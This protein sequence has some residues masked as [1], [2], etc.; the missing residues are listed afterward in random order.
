MAEYY[1]YL[2]NK[3][4]IV[5]DT[6]TVLTDVQQEFKDLLGGD[7][8]VSPET[9]QGRI[10]ELIARCRT[11]VLQTAAASSNVFNLNKA[12]GF[13]LD[14][15]GSL[16]L[17]SRN[18]A[19]YTTTS[20]VLGGVNGTIVPAGTRLQTTDGDIFVNTE[21][22]TIGSAENAVFRAEKLG[23]VPCPVGTL[24]IILDAVNGLETATNVS[25]SL[26][27]DLESDNAFR[28]RIRNSL[29]VNSIAVLSAIKANLD[30]L[31]GVAST[32]LYDNYTNSTYPLDEIS[33]GAH[34]LLAV[35]DGG[36]DQEIANVLYAKKTI[37]TGYDISTESQ[38]IEI[39]TK[40]VIDPNYGTEYT[41][42]FARP[43]STN[44]LVEISVNRQGYTGSDL[45]GDI[46]AAIIEWANGDDPE[47]DGITIGST[48]SPFE[49][50]AAVSNSIPEI[51][52]NYVKVAK[53]G[54]TPDTDFIVL[55]KAE[56]GV[57]LASN[58]TVTIQ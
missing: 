11:F 51:F 34:S 15:L 2:T 58:I 46:K 49:I 4:V 55:D 19:T 47:V 25:T 1:D 56:K 23:I 39:V 3:G 48:I 44:I 36:D 50:S 22:Y 54:D 20:V 16:F 43:L 35:V 6:S 52:I 17:L 41:V 29:N 27:T 13:G 10:I 5:P 38:D 33:I 14:D 18:P 9:P 28:L 32:Y 53:D 37:G 57:V 42:K 40:T 8:D 31:P 7:L 26:G 12:N 24:T 30:A 21:N 45:E